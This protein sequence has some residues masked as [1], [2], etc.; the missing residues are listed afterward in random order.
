MIFDTLNL[1]TTDGSLFDVATVNG[2]GMN[3]RCYQPT[4][5]QATAFLSL[6]NSSSGETIRADANGYINA[7]SVKSFD[8]IWLNVSMSTP[9]YWNS[10]VPGLNFLS[11]WYNNSATYDLPVWSDP[12]GA[13]RSLNA[14]PSEL[15]S[16]NAAT[17][18][19]L[20]QLAQRVWCSNLGTS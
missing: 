2:T 7:S 14:L 10:S 1:N 15:V 12:Q 5:V 3:V 16:F 11:E 6:T 9:P 13:G 17:R 4:D 19:Y 8:S 18:T 20:L